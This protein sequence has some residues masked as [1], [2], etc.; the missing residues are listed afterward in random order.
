[1]TMM[2]K[3]RL[4]AIVLATTLLSANTA[5]A[6]VCETY[7]A[8]ISKKTSDHHHQT[9]AAS[10]SGHHHTHAQQHRADCPECPNT[11]GQSSLHLPGCGSFTLVQ[12][13]QENLRVLA[14][15]RPVSQ[16]DVAKSS[17]GSLLTPIK[18]NIF[19][20]LHSP[21]SVSNFQPVLVSIRI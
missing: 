21:P 9:A 4:A 10:S 8:G 17:T 15:D 5:M 18:S 2:L 7:C 14:D 19:S 13:M 20:T 1:M 3:H 16:H 12:A 6:A 11:A